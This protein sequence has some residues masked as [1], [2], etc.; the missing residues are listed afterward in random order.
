MLFA[1]RRQAGLR[2]TLQATLHDGKRGRWLEGESRSVSTQQAF[3]AVSEGFDHHVSIN[4]WMT[5]FSLTG[6][7]LLPCMPAWQQLGTPL[8]F[9]W[10]LPSIA[11]PVVAVWEGASR[12]IS[13][14]TQA[15]DPRV[16]SCSVRESQPLGDFW[17]IFYFAIVL[18]DAHGNTKRSQFQNLTL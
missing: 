16:R 4:L 18:G 13:H 15:Q 17:R 12:D 14:P 9:R 11:V 8:C 6:C 1:C 10:R 3:T 7:R 2:R 5:A